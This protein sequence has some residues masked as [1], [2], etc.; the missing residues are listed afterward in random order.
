MGAQDY[1][2]FSIYLG[3]CYAGEVEHARALLINYIR[4]ERRDKAPVSPEIAEELARLEATPGT[5]AAV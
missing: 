2:T 3:Y 4:H 1:E 5:L